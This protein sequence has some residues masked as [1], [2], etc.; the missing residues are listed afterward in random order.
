MVHQF[1]RVLA[2]VGEEDAELEVGGRGGELIEVDG[3]GGRFTVELTQD[4]FAID[5]TAVLGNARKVIT[6]LHVEDFAHFL[7]FFEIEG[8]YVGRRRVAHDN[9]IAKSTHIGF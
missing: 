1:A 4:P 8:F 6:H 5:E 3:E 7:A 2:T 9:E